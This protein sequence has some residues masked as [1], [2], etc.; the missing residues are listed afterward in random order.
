[1]DKV[2]TIQQKIHPAVKLHCALVNVVHLKEMELMHADESR[3]D[4][5]IGGDLEPTAAESRE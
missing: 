3:G 5:N 4:G 1:M 2:A